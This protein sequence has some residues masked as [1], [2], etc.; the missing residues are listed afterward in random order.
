VSYPAAL[1]E[2]QQLQQSIEKTI[3]MAAAFCQLQLLS[4]QQLN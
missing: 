2:K 4:N 3:A 1:L